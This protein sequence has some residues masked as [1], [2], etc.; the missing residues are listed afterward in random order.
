MKTIYILIFL[1]M[2]MLTVNI[3]AISLGTNITIFDMVNSGNTGW[4]GTQEDNEVEP[5]NIKSQKWDLEGFFLNNSILTIVGGYDFEKGYNNTKAGDIFID[6]NGDVNYGPLNDNTGYNN[7]TVKNF[8]GYDYVLDLD[9]EHFTY[10]VYELSSLSNLYSVYH[11]E[12]QESNAWKYKDNGTLLFKDLSFDYWKGLNDSAVGGLL[13]GN[14]Y[15]ASFDLSFFNYKEG[16]IVHNTMSCGNDNLM[17][18]HHS[19]TPEPITAV[20]FGLGILG[21]FLSKKKNINK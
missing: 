13:G 18:Q 5:G 14:H 2:Q 12:N 4:Y 6:V 7:K 20:F 1:I 19:E 15:A 3:F 16:F 9:F 17:G 11:K 8:F 21:I 10:S